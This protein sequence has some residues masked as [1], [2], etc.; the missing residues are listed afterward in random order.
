VVTL[1][2]PELNADQMV[3]VA[4][5]AE[6]AGIAAST[7]RAYIARGEADVPL[8]QAVLNSRSAWA[9]P[10][11]EEWA[12]Q[13]QR[14]PDGVTQA[15]SADRARASLPVGVAERWG[16]FTRVF[17]ALLWERAAVRKRWALRWRTEA[18]VRDVAEPADAV[19]LAGVTG[20]TGGGLV[21]SGADSLKLVEYLQGRRYPAAL[22]ADRQKYKGKRRKLATLRP[23]LRPEGVAPSGQSG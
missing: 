9:R 6:F 13:R 8:P 2:A 23:G 18:A 20:H 15:V 16:R 4:E 12:E 10:V 11:A 1:A 22:L 17:F 5:M 7:L 19:P 14:S 21:V 3:S